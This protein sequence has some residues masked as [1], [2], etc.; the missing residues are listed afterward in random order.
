MRSTECQSSYDGCP[1]QRGGLYDRSRLS[2][3][4]VCVCVHNT[5]NSCGRMWMNVCFA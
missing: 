5:S 2:C 4:F 3:V 1:P